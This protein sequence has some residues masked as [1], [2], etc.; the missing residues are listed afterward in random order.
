MEQTG[1]INNSANLFGG[2]IY[3]TSTSV[4]VQNC[5]FTNN[6]AGALL[7]Y[8]DVLPA[9]LSAGWCM[10]CNLYRSAPGLGPVFM[11]CFSMAAELERR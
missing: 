8:R 11:T 3:G 2:A 10:L 1:F 7:A 6:S 5:A 9:G 4:M